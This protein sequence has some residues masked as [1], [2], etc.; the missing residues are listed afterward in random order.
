MFSPYVTTVAAISLLWVWIFDPTHGL[1]NYLLSLVGIDGPRWLSTT[2][3][4]MPALIIM[5]VWRVMGYNMV[6]FLAGLTS[7]SQEFYDA[8]TVDGA[9]RWHTFRHITLPLLSP[10]TFFLLVTSLIGALQV[11]DSVAVMTQGQ[12]AGAT[13]V[14]NFYIYQRAFVMMRA[15]YASTIAM[16]LFAIIISLTILQLR[17]SQRWVHY[18]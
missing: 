17:L 11:F 6:I 3:W 2:T 4:A 18:Q 14:F 9:G 16:V 1:M 8:A 12:P 15:G 5:R 7:I 13:R 10:T